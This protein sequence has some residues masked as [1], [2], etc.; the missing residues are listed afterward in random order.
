MNRSNSL[1]SEC[2]AALLELSLTLT[3]LFLVGFGCLEFSRVLRE[4]ERATLLSRESASIAFRDCAADTGTKLVECLEQ[5]RQNMERFGRQ[6]AGN[7][8]EVII[9]LYS[10][11]ETGEIT[12]VGAAGSGGKPS[13]FADVPEQDALRAAIASHR[14]IVIAES[15]V[16]FHS[17]FGEPGKI[18]WFQPTHLYVATVI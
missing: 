2:G 4:T 9:S 6:I 3:L 14:L 11:G 18:L 7:D 8:V 1:H 10:Q 5:T 15:F 16:P 13:R 17:I 12:R